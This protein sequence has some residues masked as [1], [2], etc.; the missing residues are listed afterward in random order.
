MIFYILIPHITG[1]IYDSNYHLL[2]LLSDFYNIADNVLEY[3]SGITGLP[4]KTGHWNVN[5]PTTT[6]ETLLRIYYLN[7][8]VLQNVNILLSAIQTA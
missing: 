7:L 2:N 5:I 3:E 1:R 4:V 6:A 8:Y